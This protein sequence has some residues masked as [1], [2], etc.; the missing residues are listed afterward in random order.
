MTTRNGI[1]SGCF[2]VGLGDDAPHPRCERCNIPL[3]ILALE[4]HDPAHPL[5]LD[6]ASWDNSNRALDEIEKADGVDE[7]SE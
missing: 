5:C 4:S 2:N 3:S 1:G 7:R 6:C